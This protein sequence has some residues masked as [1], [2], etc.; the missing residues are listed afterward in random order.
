MHLQ[1]RYSTNP[2]GFKKYSIFRIIGNETPPRDEPDARLKTL[3]FILENEPNFPNC[4][5]CW[6]LNC[7]HDKIRRDYLCKLLSDYE[8]HV[9]VVPMLRKKYEKAKNIDE[10][11]NWLIGINRARNL[12]IGRAH[13]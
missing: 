12:E 6:V 11:I 4:I 1:K 8:H 9:V 5:K 10:K 2:N 7:I 13:V 3:K